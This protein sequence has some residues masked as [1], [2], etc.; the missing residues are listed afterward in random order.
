M[1]ACG[2]TPENFARSSNI[3]QNYLFFYNEIQKASHYNRPALQGR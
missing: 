2:E 3:T 1:I